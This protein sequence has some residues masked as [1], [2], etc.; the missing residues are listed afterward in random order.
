MYRG[1]LFYSLRERE[2]CSGLKWTKSELN[3]PQWIEMDQCKLKWTEVELCGLNGIK[4]I[5]IYVDIA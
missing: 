2:V 1:T 5:E 4:W 3:G